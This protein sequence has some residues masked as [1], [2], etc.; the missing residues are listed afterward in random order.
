MSW[1]A[2]AARSRRRSETSSFTIDRMGQDPGLCALAPFVVA[3]VDLD[4]GPR[5]IGNI[6]DCPFEQLRV[7]MSVEVFFEVVD[8]APLLRFRQLAS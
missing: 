7:E 2:G 8:E 3:V 1:R 5:V 6:V 4:D